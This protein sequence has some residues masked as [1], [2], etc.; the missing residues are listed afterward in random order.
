[1]IIVLGNGPGDPSS[2]LGQSGLFSP[3]ANALEKGLNLSLLSSTMG[4]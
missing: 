4:K 2:N 3:C 1:M